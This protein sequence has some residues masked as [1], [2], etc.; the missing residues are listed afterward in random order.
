MPTATSGDTVRIHYTGT[1]ATG[2]PFDSSMGR[3]PLEFTL[4]SGQVIPGFDTGV[5]GMAPGESK[6]ITIPAADAYGPRMEEMTMEVP[7]AQLPAE[8]DPQVGDQL[9]VGTASGEQFPVVI[10]AVTDDSVTLDANHPLAGQ[11]LTFDLTL[12]EIVG[13]P[14][15]S[16]LVGLDGR[17]LGGDPPKLIL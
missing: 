1:L 8:A 17:P 5:A 16:G 15:S 4:G 2:E 11:D 3:D 13:K 10:T 6:R 14:A 12:V 9:V 7:R